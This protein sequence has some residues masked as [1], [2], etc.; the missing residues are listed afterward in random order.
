MATTDARAAIVREMAEWRKNKPPS[1]ARMFGKHG[2]T[3]EQGAAHDELLRAWNRQYRA[4]RK[5][6][7]EAGA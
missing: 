1:L 3:L 2:P 7:K 6:L 5:R 4:L